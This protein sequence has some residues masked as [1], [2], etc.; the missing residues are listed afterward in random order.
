MPPM[1]QSVDQIATQAR[2][3]CKSGDYPR[4]MILYRKALKLAKN[5]AELLTRYAHVLLL[6][7]Y[8]QEGLEY[9]KRACKRRP[10]HPRTMMILAFAKLRLSDIEGLHETLDRV[11]THDPTFWPAMLAKVDLCIDSGRPE[12]AEGILDTAFQSEN[13]DPLVYIA[14]AKLARST[15][16]YSS[17]IDAANT[18]LALEDISL[19]HKIAA[20]FALGHL[21]DATG[22]YD[23]A[24]EAFH[25]ANAALP[26]ATPTHA[27]S[28]IAAWSK[29]F[30][31]Q[32]NGPANESEKPVV[33]VGMP[34]SG[35]TLTE[36]I[37]LAHPLGETVGEAPLLLQQFQ[38]TT[39][40][41]ITR[42]L[43]NSYA[44]EYIEYIDGQTGSG[45]LRVVDKH[46]NAAKTVGMI[47]KMFPNARFIHCLRDP[48]DCCLS[49]YFQNFGHN[50]TYARDLQTLGRQ[51]IAHRELMDHWGEVIEQPILSHVYE[52]L[53]DD[54]EPRVRELLNH[55]GLEYDD[56]CMRFHEST[57]HVLTA[58]ATQVR[59]PIYTS[60]KQR[61]KNYEKHLGPLLD[62]L[63]GYASE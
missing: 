3:A 20:G 61:W 45:S 9:A 32:M 2:E 53:V 34:R 44:N 57:R 51:Y 8:L 29:S 5:D 33:V 17:G 25:T 40:S 31:D 50:L 24:I 16:D 49:A 11:L 14:K 30:L 52:D 6:A 58:S 35:T 10:N 56:S 21:L 54:P 4:S 42:E 19:N 28:T 36:Q 38:R 12:L 41:N 39:P 55:V 62:V 27:A 15:K 37:I 18:A 23:G 48:V 43:L 26:A 7:G 22:E 59:K 46:M 60:S 63:G 47:S 13:P 1:K